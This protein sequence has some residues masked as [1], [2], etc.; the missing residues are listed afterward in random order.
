MDLIFYGDS[1]F[2][3]VGQWAIFFHRLLQDKKS[4][5]IH[6]H[7]PLLTIKKNA[8]VNHLFVCQWWKYKSFHKPSM[9]IVIA[10]VLLCLLKAS[11]P[12]YVLQIVRT[13]RKSFAH[14]Q[15]GYCFIS[16]SCFAMRTG[17]LWSSDVWASLI[18]SASGVTRLRCW[19]DMLWLFALWPS[20]YHL[21]HPL[22]WA[23][24]QIWSQTSRDHR[25]SKTF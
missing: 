19:L 25:T 12:Y 3:A 1:V 18:R 20:L 9:V 23:S 11:R 21:K 22:F 24:T 16:I 4:L 17:W 8:G 10:M 2:I 13:N 5:C 6:S 7:H 14:E 15:I